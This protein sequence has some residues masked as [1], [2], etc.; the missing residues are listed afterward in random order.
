MAN[1]YCRLIDVAVSNKLG[2]ILVINLLNNIFT[3][4]ILIH[5]DV[6]TIVDDVDIKW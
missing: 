2:R 1:Q 3:L 5:S 6:A 4:S